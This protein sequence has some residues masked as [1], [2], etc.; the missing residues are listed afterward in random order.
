MRIRRPEAA[1]AAACLLWAALLAGA[2]ADAGAGHAAGARRDRPDDPRGVLR[3]EAEGDRLVGRGRAGP[4]RSSSRAATRRPS[5]TPIYDRLLATLS[6]SH[7]FRM[8]AGRLPERGWGTAGLRIGQDGDGYA[9]KGVLPGSSAERGRTEDRR[10]HPR[11]RRTKVRQ[12]TR[13]LPGALL[14]VRGRSGHVRPGDLAARRR[15]RPASSGSRARPRNPATR[16]SGRARASSARTAR[17]TA[18]RTSGA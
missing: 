9:V 4:R 1:L 8:P 5:R 7:T 16:S 2:D 12:G 11:G 15:R 14:R 10:P 17:P 13:E 3:S 6:D 18:T